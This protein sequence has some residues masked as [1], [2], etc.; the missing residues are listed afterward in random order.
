MTNSQETE[1][2]VARPTHEQ[3]QELIRELRDPNDTSLRFKA[4]AADWLQALEAERERLAV[5]LVDAV[6]LA[7]PALTKGLEEAK[8]QIEALQAS[9][10]EVGRVGEQGLRSAIS[11][12]AATREPISRAAGEAE[13]SGLT[14]EILPSEWQ[15]ETL[16]DAPITSVF[17]QAREDGGLRVWSDDE[18]GLIL[19]GHDA[20]AVSG[21]IW[22][23]IKALRQYRLTGSLDQ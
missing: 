11:Q 8:R 21:A 17:L 9:Q 7:H 1:G 6:E 3:I 13:P 14:S 4:L 20:N 23:A 16:S 18:P 12:S 2:L 5:A 19:S 10:A 15:V 22:P